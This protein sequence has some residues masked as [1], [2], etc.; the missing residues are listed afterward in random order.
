MYTAWNLILATEEPVQISEETSE[1]GGIDLLLP[2]PE[3]LIAGLIAFI[4][5]FLVVWKYALP[6]LKETLEGRQE[7]VRSE[8]RAAEVSKEEAA[9]LL[10]DYRT[11]IAGANEEAAQIVA[12][13]R[14]AG[15]AVKADIV[16][17]AESEAEAV[18]AR[19]ADDVASERERVADDLRR[20]VADL[21]ISVAERVVTSNIDEDAQRVLVDRYIDE[22]GGVQ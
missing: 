9:S 18:K 5:I 10:E 13:A 17:R 4:I 15:E 2:A 21:S 19:A 22:L 12:D 3:E 16:A 14:E 6:V 11:Q 8:L 20:Q 7:A 1:S